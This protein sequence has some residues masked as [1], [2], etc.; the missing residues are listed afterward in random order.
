[1]MSEISDLAAAVNGLQQVAQELRDRSDVQDK[2]LA[3]LDLLTRYGQTN[4]RGVMVATSAVVLSLIV[5]GFAI[6]LDTQLT[7]TTH[8]LAQVQ[9]RTSTEVL[10]PLYQVFA[11]SLQVNAAP[12]NYTPAQIDVRRRATE[13]IIGPNGGLVKLGCGSG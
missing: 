7:A 4:R 1:M 9:V 11:L 3:R 12:P 6:Y 13:A 5:G 10:C 8:Q 2:V